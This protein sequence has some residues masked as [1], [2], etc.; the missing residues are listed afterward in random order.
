MLQLLLQALQGGASLELAAL[1]EKFRSLNGDEKTN[2]LILSIK[3]SF[4]LLQTVTDKTKTKVDDILVN[5]VLNA[6]PK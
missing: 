6:L 4:L 3:N 2:E 5:I 1:L